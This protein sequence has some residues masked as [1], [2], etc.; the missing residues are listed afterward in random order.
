MEQCSG[1]SG[2]CW[3]VEPESGIEA[4]GSRIRGAPECNT[5]FRRKAQLLR[6]MSDV[7]DPSLPRC[8]Q[9]GMTL[10][11]LCPPV[12]QIYSLRTT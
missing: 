7:L 9:F 12:V 5:C 3:C 2:F 10:S 6:S 8:D 1:S 11:R 4:P